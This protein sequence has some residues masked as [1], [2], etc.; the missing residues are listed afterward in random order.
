[1][2]GKHDD[3][4]KKAEHHDLRDALYTAL[5]PQP[6]DKKSADDRYRHEKAHFPW[7]C[8]HRAEDLADPVRFR[9]GEGT[10]TNFQK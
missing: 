8:Q 2:H 3:E 9:R 1:M 4:R 5:E 6:A 7:T 10:M